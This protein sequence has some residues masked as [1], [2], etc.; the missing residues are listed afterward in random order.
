M[1]VDEAEFG[2]EGLR[3]GLGRAA[4]SFLVVVGRGV[5]G[6]RAGVEGVS[7]ADGALRLVG[8]GHVGLDAN[9]AKDVA[10][11]Q[12]RVA[13]FHTLRGLGAD[14]QLADGTVWVES[15]AIVILLAVLLV[16]GHRGLDGRLGHSQN[17]RHG[18]G[19]DGGK[20]EEAE[21]DKVGGARKRHE[22]KDRRVDESS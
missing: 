12:Q 18:N 4:A 9:A 10:A 5:H 20:M 17:G 8:D 1:A 3:R 21:V 16:A 13:L 19:V 11:G 22:G 14:G 7:T 6:V 2:E 15:T